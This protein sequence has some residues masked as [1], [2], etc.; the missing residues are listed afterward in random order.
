MR[1]GS[2]HQCEHLILPSNGI[3]RGEKIVQRLLIRLLNTQNWRLLTL[4]IM[5]VEVLLGQ[6]V[7]LG[8]LSSWECVCLIYRAQV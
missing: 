6:S 4:G 5:Y 2:S 1:E 3:E 8:P 7:V